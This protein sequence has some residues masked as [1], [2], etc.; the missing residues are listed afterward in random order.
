ML[1][2]RLR[3]L[4]YR[5]RRRK[6][7]RLGAGREACEHQHVTGRQRPGGDESPAGR[8]AAGPVA[9]DR[10]LMTVGGGLRRFVPAG[11]RAVP[12][13]V[14]KGRTEPGMS[15]QLARLRETIW[16]RPKALVRFA[17]YEIRIA[18]GSSFYHQCRYVFADRV[19]HF[20]AQREDPLIIDGWSNIGVSILYFKW[21]YPKSRIHR[22]RA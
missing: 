2:A 22:V 9:T 4:R 6:D 1:V 12:W 7:V 15:W 11:I 8:A 5:R 10:R 18:E 3:T 21:V 14:L 19:Y 17:G 13:Y 16:A 20:E